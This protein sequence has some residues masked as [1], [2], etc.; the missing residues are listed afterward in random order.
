MSDS[1]VSC[2]L[3]QRSEETKT[4]GTLSTKD[5]VTAHQN[6][7]LFSSGIFC[8][9]SPEFDDLFGFSVEDV[10]KEVKRGSKLTCN[11]CKRKG[12]TAGCEVKRC[13]KSYHYPCAVKEGAKAIEDEVNGSYVIYCSPHY[14]RQIQAQESINRIASS[15]KKPR[16]SKT[17]KNSSEPGPSKVFC[18]ACEQREGNVSLE[19]LS[20]SIMLYC[21]KHVPA[22][23]KKNGNG[24]GPSA[25]NSDS[26]SS[27]STTRTS[28]KRWLGDCDKQ[29][30]TRYKHKPEGWKK[31]ISDS[32][33]SV[34]NDNE[35]N[36]PMDICAPLESDIDESANSVP[37]LKTVPEVIRRDIENPAGSPSGN[38]V[39]DENDKDT[40]IDSDAESESLLLPVEICVLPEPLTLSTAELSPQTESAPQEDFLVK[41]DIEPVKKMHKGSRPEQKAVQSPG[42]HTSA[43]SVPRPSSADLLPS[44]GQSKSP[45]CTSPA[46]FPAPPEPVCVSIRSSS[47]P[48]ALPSVSEPKIDS[49]TFWKSCN[50]AG[51]TQAIFTDFINSMNDISNKIQS[52]QA[53]QE[54]YDLALSVMA[55][56]GK[57]AEF[58]A[59][60]QEELQKKQTDL[61]KAAAAMKE[62]VSALRK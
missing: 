42:Q 39:E 34:D 25:H 57:L 5:E 12:A 61:Q 2:I 18:L 13:Q 27:N 36:M 22:S 8:R 60:Q 15:T 20:N 50:V 47:S 21:D 30:E 49:T 7:L 23:H 26:S 19:S 45:P 29:E 16:T 62:V 38:H 28:S 44:F 54:E 48:V 56:S 14:E 33:N 24:A 32:S 9:D 4:T 58:V 43:P 37:E 59:K 51:C 41:A 6:C 17:L 1:T 55:A 35:D 11:H 46:I 3:C 52:D 40:I 10:L 31:R 53:S